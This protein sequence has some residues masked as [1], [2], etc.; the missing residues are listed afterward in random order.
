MHLFVYGTLRKKPSSRVLNTVHQQFLSQAMFCGEAKLNGYL[1]SLGSYPGLLLD[2]LA[3]SQ[4]TGEIYQINET[5]LELLDAYEE[6]DN[7]SENTEYQRILKTIVSD[8]GEKFSVWIY[9][10]K[11]S[12]NGIELIISGD[13]CAD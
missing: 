5:D 9:V 10:M 1:Y 11:T 3:E 13:W 12:T 2:D 8:S 4:V 7:D 6:I